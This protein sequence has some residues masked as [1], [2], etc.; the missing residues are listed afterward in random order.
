MSLFAGISTHS[1]NEAELARD[2]E[3][4]AAKRS[5]ATEIIS[6]IPLQKSISTSSIV[7]KE[8]IKAIARHLTDSE[9]ENQSLLRAHAKIEVY[10]NVEKRRKR[11]SLFFR[12]KKD[13]T[14]MKSI[15]GQVANCDV[16]GVSLSLGTLKDHQLECKGGSSGG[17][18]GSTAGIVGGLTKKSDKGEMG[19]DFYDGPEQNSNYNDDNTPLIRSIRIS[20]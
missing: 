2:F 11:G 4:I 1:L 8:D 20:K 14:K 5:L 17:K 10:D 16:C 3:R 18:K 12:K 13:K 15:G 9:D 6:R 7:A 19:Q